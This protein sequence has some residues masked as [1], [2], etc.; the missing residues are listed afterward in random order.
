VRPIAKVIKNGELAFVI[1][2]DGTI[3]APPAI[4]PSDASDELTRVT[5][6]F[7]SG[8]EMSSVERL[9]LEDRWKIVI[10]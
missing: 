10:T 1:R 5:F 7:V 4:F 9:K 3:G 6:V 2:T 8:S